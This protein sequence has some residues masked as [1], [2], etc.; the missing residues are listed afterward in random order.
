MLKDDEG[1]AVIYDDADKPGDHSLLKTYGVGNV[2]IEAYLVVHWVQK[3][4]SL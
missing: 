1:S 3:K 2:R 4:T